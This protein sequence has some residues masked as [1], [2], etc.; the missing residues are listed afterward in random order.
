[1]YKGMTPNLCKISTSNQGKG[2]K[3][4]IRQI[5]MRIP[6]RIYLRKCEKTTTSN[7]T[8]Y[9]ELNSSFLL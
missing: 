9:I 1:M 6:Q 7:K 5:R 4:Q 3:R 8:V 2:S